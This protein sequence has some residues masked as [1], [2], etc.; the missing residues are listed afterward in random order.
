MCFTPLY[1]YEDNVLHGNS[2]VNKIVWNME[3]DAHVKAHNT[4]ATVCVV[5]YTSENYY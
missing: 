1:H 3:S 4:F 5:T 2:N